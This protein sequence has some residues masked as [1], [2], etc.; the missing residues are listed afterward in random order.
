MYSSNI[1][2]TVIIGAGAAGIG[3][4]VLFEKM[5][6]KNYLILEKDTVGSS[7]RQWPTHTRFISPSFSGNAF[8]IVDLNAVTPDTSP[9]YTLKTEHPSGIEYATY[10]ESLTNHFNLKIKEETA[11]LAITKSDDIFTLD[12]AGKTFHA[13]H[14]VW[15]GGEFQQPLVPDIPGAKYGI[16]SS[17]VVN[18]ENDELVI[19]GGYESGFDLAIEAMSQGKKVTIIDAGTPWDVSSSDSSISLSPRT[20]DRISPYIGSDQLT[21]IGDTRVIAIEKT[22]PDYQIK[23]NRGYIQSS[24]P[25]IFATGFKNLPEIASALFTDAPQGNVLLTKHD[26]STITPGCFLIGPKVQHG[27]IVFCFIYKYR[28]RLPVVAETIVDRLGLQLPLPT[29]YKKPGMYLNNLADCGA[30]CSC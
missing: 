9:A 30:E 27:E 19:I 2:D 5:E 15:A 8:G 14:I 21:L 12:T 11:V 13:K 25:P 17:T 24:E 20:R 1:Y 26:E 6:L 28:Q 22:K 16:H 29:E 3:L 23:T 7:F 18:T 4:G 10:L